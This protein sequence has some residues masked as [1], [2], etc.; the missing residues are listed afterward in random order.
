MPNII[1]INIDPYI[2]ANKPNKIL[3]DF[4]ILNNKL[5]IIII[6]TNMA[7]SQICII[8]ITILLIPQKI[9]GIY[10]INFIIITNINNIIIDTILSTLLLFVIRKNKKVDNNI[11][12]D[13][14]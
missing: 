2:E 7:N 12:I 13:N 8:N 6:V 10:N 4:I 3:F 11:I 1:S 14:K 9:I 5:A